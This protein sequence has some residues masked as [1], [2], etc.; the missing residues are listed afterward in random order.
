MSTLRDALSDDY[1]RP[2]STAPAVCH[3]LPLDDVLGDVGQLL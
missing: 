3:S 1:G 2:S